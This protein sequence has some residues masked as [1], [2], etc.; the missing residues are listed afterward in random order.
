MAL[1]IYYG[2]GEVKFPMLADKNQKSYFLNIS[3]VFIMNGISPLPN[4]FFKCVKLL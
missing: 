4:K 3:L 2:S 1:S